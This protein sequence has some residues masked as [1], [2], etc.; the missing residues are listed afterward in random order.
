MAFLVKPVL[1]EIFFKRNLATLNLLPP[2]IVLLYVVKGVFGYGQSYLMSFVGQR[3]VA[4]MR[5][6]CIAHLQS[7]PYPISTG[8]P[9]A[10]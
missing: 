6:N 3:I 5:D 4:N 9:R 1:D 2:F 8:P 7:C 10:C